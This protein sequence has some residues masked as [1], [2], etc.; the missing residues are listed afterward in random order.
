MKYLV[1][2]ADDFGLCSGVNRGC[3]EALKNGLV[4]ELS[5]V[6]S[7]PGT[8]AAVKLA[9]DNNIN[10]VG[11]HLTLNDYNNT[12]E[13][14]RTADYRKMLIEESAENLQALAR[15]ELD[16]FEHLMGRPPSHITSHQHTQQ[17]PKLVEMIAAYATKHGIYIRRAANFSHDENP[18]G[19]IE[20]ANQEYARLGVKFADYFFGHVQGE[21]EKV[22]AAF[23][24]ELNSVEDNSVTELMFHPG[25]IDE[26]LSKYSTMTD[27]RERD[28]KLAKDENFQNK[29]NELGFRLVSFAEIDQKK[30]N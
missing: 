24:K 9:Q 18:V 6:V 22:K 30:L 21:Y 23:L 4:T 26:F 29:I 8:K 10:E 19:D 12:G 2:V 25:F 14:L 15:K 16:T 5:L 28:I 7:W 11:I 27:T 13:Y 3:I 17:H 1:V 20:K